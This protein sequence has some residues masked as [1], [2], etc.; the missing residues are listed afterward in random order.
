MLENTLMVHGGPEAIDA[1]IDL[2][3]DGERGA[4]KPASRRDLVHEP[5]R[6]PVQSHA[7]DAALWLPSRPT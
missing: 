5:M 2:L 4:W 3:I 1:I 7:G 6:E